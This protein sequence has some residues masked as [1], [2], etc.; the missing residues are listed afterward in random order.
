LHTKCTKYHGNTWCVGYNCEDLVMIGCNL[1]KF[2][3]FKTI[4]HSWYSGD[5][6][7]LNTMT[8][9]KNYSIIFLIYIRCSSIFDSCFYDFVNLFFI[10]TSFDLNSTF[11][12]IS[13]FLNFKS[14]WFSCVL[15]FNFFEL[16]TRSSWKHWS[17]LQ[18]IC[19]HWSI[20]DFGAHLIFKG[21]W[22]V[23]SSFFVQLLLLL[24][25]LET[26][27]IFLFKSNKD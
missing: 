17:S 8:V 26:C 23:E 9:Q 14:T 1:L 18:Y 15:N 5:F 16:G 27:V 13:F 6:K 25:L 3:E 4:G 2:V 7:I 24:L 11:T 21:H 22:M 10:L 12:C 19:Q 20:L